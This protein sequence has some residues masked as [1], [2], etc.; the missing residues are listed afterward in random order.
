MLHYDEIEHV[1][2]FDTLLIQVG[3]SEEAIHT[4]EERHWKCPH[5]L[6]SAASICT[7]LKAPSNTYGVTEK[8]LNAKILEPSYKQAGQN[9]PP[10]RILQAD[11]G[12]FTS[13]THLWVRQASCIFCSGSTAS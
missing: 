1:R 8:V 9:R 12:L 10:E 6:N 3:V 5:G 11:T 13:E 2:V 7:R 4:R